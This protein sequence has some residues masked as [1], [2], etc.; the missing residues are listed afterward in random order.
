M[1]CVLGDVPNEVI[2]HERKEIEIPAIRKSGLI[3]HLFDF[4]VTSFKIY[5]EMTGK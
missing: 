2:V 4:I 3:Q 1:H 5:M